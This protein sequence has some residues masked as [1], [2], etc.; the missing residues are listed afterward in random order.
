MASEKTATLAIEALNK[1]RFVVQR[2][3]LEVMNIIRDYIP[4]A[5]AREASEKLFDAFFINGV[6]LTT[7]LMR[8]EYEEWKTLELHSL[9][10]QPL[11]RV[12]P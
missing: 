10:L 12:Q 4:E 7:N 8:K 3:V 6:E 5:C 1:D 9:M 2:S 11:A